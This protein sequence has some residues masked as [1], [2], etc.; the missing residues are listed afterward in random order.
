[1]NTSADLTPLV[2][3]N[4]VGLTPELAREVPTLNAML[5]DGGS[6][7][8]MKGVFPGL[9][10]TAQASMLSGKEPTEHG[11][12]ANGWYR[13][14]VGEVRS[15]IQARKQ[16][17]AEVVDELCRRKAQSLGKSFTSARLFWWFAQ[18]CDNDIVVTPKPH[19]G[20]DGSKAF[21]IQTRPAALG[22]SLESHFGA[23]PF[24]TFWGPMAGE[25]SSRWIAEASASVIRDKHPTL[26]MV[27]LP[28]LD[29]DLQRFGP[30]G[31]DIPRLLGEL[32]ACLARVVEAAKSI[33]ARVMVVSEYGISDVHTP[34]DINRQLCRMG[35]LET[36]SGPYGDML[37]VMDSRAFAVADHQI[38]HVYLKNAC[39]HERVREALFNIPGIEHVLDRDAQ[40]EFAINHARSGDFVLIAEEGHWFSYGWWKDPERAP[41][42][43]RTVDIHRKPGYDPCE[44]FFDPKLS[45]PKF[46]VVRRLLA[47]KLGFRNLMDVVPLD[48]SLVKGSHGRPESGDHD[49]PLLVV[50][51]ASQMPDNPKMT[52][53]SELVQKAIGLS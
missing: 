42:F 37:D 13:E 21:D 19:Y 33:G 1:M 51:D 14:D 43:A 20:A 35:L 53:I 31:A 45:A 5:A 12:V 46:K 25:G 18:G 28:H 7:S 49:S 34:I 27:Y 38:A 17:Q 3:I 2:L 23:F 15:W 8:A 39:D 48:T 6:L 50:D 40:A 44:L 24:H 9:T 32:D 41:D 47:R 52:D 30:S 4:A 11:V 36:R 29:Y 22:K 26:S 10:C 16:I